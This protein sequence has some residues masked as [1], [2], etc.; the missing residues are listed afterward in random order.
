MSQEITDG[1]MREMLGKSKLFTVVLLRTTDAYD[2][3]AAP[4]SEQRR[5]IWAHGKR[6]FELRASGVMPMVGPLMKP[7]FAG[8]AVFTVSPE[9]TQAIMEGDPAVMAGY[10]SF[11]ILP[12]RTF[13]GDGLPEASSA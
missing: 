6:N 1:Y 10:F 5:V 12:W 9:E 2:L 4:D 3:D 11:E 7:P 13:P 8:L